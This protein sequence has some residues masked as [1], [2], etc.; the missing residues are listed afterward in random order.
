MDSTPINVLWTSGWDST[1]RVASLVIDQGRTVQPWYVLDTGRR[2]TAVELETQG[3]IRAALVSMDPAARDRLLPIKTARIE[4]IPA[5]AE[6]TRQYQALRERGHLGTQYDWLSRFAKWRNIT[7]ELSIHLDDKAHDFLDGHVEEL[8]D[9]TYRLR[10]DE[11]EPDLQVFAPFIFPLFDL[12]KPEMQQRAEQMGFGHI[13]EMTWF[14]FN[15]LLDRTPCGSC[16]PCKYTAEEGLGRRVPA[17]TLRRKA[18]ATALLAAWRIRN[19][20]R[21]EKRLS[22]IVSHAEI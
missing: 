18:E 19:L 21:N 10:R 16:N 11:A 6:I 3:K 8:I 14:C 4:D 12:S 5:N 20:A 2:S 7:L 9:G 15:P 13:M 1:F 17:P 22:E